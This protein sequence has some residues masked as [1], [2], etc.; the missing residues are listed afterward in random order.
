MRAWAVVMFLALSG[1]AQVWAEPPAR[2][3]DK[4]V[5]GRGYR[6]VRVIAQKAGASLVQAVPAREGG[7]QLLW[8]RGKS[9]LVLAT[10]LLVGAQEELKLTSVRP[11]FDRKDLTE[12]VVDSSYSNGFGGDAS[13]THYLVGD[14]PSLACSFVSAGSSA[15]E[16]LS[17]SFT[18]RLAKISDE[19]L[20]FSLTRQEQGRHVIGGGGGLPQVQICELPA[21][22][23]CTCTTAPATGIGIGTSPR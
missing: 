10:S 6:D 21:R 18:T 20:R 12:I 14:P 1:A 4:L 7:T 15:M 11:F 5:R 19:P 8:V 23:A 9:V 3:V 17:S 22:G 13:T 16:D 2:G